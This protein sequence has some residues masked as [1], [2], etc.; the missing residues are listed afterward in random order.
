VVFVRDTD[1][2]IYHRWQVSRNGNWSGRVSVGAPPGRAT[3]VPDVAL[4][5]NGG[6]AVF[7]KGGDNAVCYAWQD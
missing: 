7:T 1:N 6:L 2:A 4:N 3:S 5:A